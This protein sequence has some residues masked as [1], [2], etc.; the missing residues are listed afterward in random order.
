MWHAARA[1]FHDYN[2]KEGS[3]IR[4]ASVGDKDVF[5]VNAYGYKRL[6]LNEVIF[7]FYGHLG[8]WSSVISVPPQARDGA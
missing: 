7:G 3:L 2:I 1:D 6:F 4:A 5:I 8:G